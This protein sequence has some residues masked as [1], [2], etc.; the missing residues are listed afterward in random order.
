MQ[1]TPT[2]QLALPIGMTGVSLAQQFILRQLTNFFS[3]QVQQH[4]ENPNE[5][6]GTANWHD[7]GIPGT[8]T[9][10]FTTSNRKVF[11]YRPNIQGTPT[12]QLAQPIGMTGVSLAE[13]LAVPF[14]ISLLS[15]C[16]I[17]NHP[18][19]FPLCSVYAHDYT[20]IPHLVVYRQFS[21]GKIIY[22]VINDL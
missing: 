19:Y 17:D 13:V 16:P 7:R 12:H 15:V 2:H 6:I 1:G 8:T 5:P 3:L 20:C 14:A 11:L 10:H 4:P 22:R 21:K 9:I 18:R